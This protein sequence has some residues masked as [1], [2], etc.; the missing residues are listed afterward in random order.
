[1]VMVVVVV[2][3]MVMVA[4]RIATVVDRRGDPGAPVVEPAAAVPATIAVSLRR[5]EVMP[6]RELVVRGLQPV[7]RVRNR[8]EQLGVSARRRDGRG[9]RRRPNGW[10]SEG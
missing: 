8:F 3:M 9:R 6:H 1:M 4:V 5:H 7:D 10:Q 2:V